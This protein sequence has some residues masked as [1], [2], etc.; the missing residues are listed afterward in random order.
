MQGEQQHGN[1]VIHT[2]LIHTKAY[3]SANN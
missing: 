2:R 1:N 3:K